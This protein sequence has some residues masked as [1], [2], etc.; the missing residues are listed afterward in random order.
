MKLQG[1]ATLPAP[2]QAAWALLNDPV[3]LARC[4]P[5]CEALEPDGPGRFKAKVKMMV[6]A[7]SGSYSGTLEILEQKEPLR[8]RLR[9]E[10][11][12]VPGF[13]NAEGTLELHEKKGQTEVRYSGEAQVGGLVASVGQ[14]MI[15]GVAKKIVQQ[16]FAAAA[17]ELE[18]APS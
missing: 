18:K 17:R 9:I 15:E 5:G 4:L 3:R 2:R 8:M 7:I 12:G 14:R 10:G 16:F 11:K 13:M 6:A 1:S